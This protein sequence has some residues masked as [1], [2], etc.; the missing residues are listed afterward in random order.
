MT[1]PPDEIATHIDAPTRF[2]QMTDPEQ[3]ALLLAHHRGT[4]IQVYCTWVRPNKWITATS[5][6]DFSEFRA[7]R[8][9]LSTQDTP[10][11]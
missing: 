4:K 10:H 7:Y 1:Y 2:G 8:A 6:P 3:A 5:S 11:D 9:A